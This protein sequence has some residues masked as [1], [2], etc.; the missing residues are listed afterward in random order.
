MP[1]TPAVPARSAAPIGA[2]LAIGALLAAGL[3][4]VAVVDRPVPACDGVA[5]AELVETVLAAAGW[6]DR[7]RLDD[8][9]YVYEYDRAADSFADDYHDVRHAGVMLSAYQVAAEGHPDAVAVG[10]AGLA[11]VQDN[12]L[13]ADGPD[14]ELATFGRPRSTVHLGAS[15]LTV[16]ALA[17][18]RLATGDHSHDELMR[19]MGRHMLT[20]L[21]DDGGM[22][23]GTRHM[24]DGDGEPSFEPTVGRT[25]TF[26]TGEAFWA[27]GLLANAFG[28]EGWDDSARAVARFIAVD[29]DLEE[30]IENPPLADQWAAYGFA[31]MRDWA[32][33]DE[34]ELG[35]VRSLI[36]AY[37]GRIDR[38]LRREA[39]RVGDG[40][41]PPD[42]SATISRGAAFGT[43]VEALSALWRLSAA[44]PGLADLHD[45]VG[46]DLV[47]GAA[48]LVARQADAAQAAGYA[49]PE[50]VEG[51]WFS[52]DVTR[53]DDQQHAM[54]GLIRTVAALQ[55]GAGV[56]GSGSSGAGGG[57]GG[58]ADLAP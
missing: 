22:W 31:E 55:A 21:R 10:D 47:C 52:D 54:A 33:L 50:L 39:K 4:V 48:V 58:W 26:Y 1:A 3:G 2:A 32:V 45:A 40:S 46:E 56:G 18:R 43:T 36:E 8:G 19:S 35:Y 20:A 57:S 6:M 28:G 12:L 44:D 9:R 14:G 53:M 37:A 30:G 49:R 25:S 7:A 5:E 13:V 29:R 38:E 24:V 23:F 34:P 11:Y 15:A 41:G 16:A 17:H 42:E 27:F 51:A